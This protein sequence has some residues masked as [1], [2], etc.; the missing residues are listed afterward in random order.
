MISQSRGLPDVPAFRGRHKS[1][2][3]R[4]KV[5]LIGLVIFSASAVHAGGLSN[6][7]QGSSAAG[8][9]ASNCPYV[10]QTSR[11]PQLR[12]EVLKFVVSRC[13][14]AIVT[15]E[16]AGTYPQGIAI[17][18]DGK[19]VLVR[20]LTNDL[21]YG[22]AVLALPSRRIISTYASDGDVVRP[23]W[24][25]DGTKISFFLLNNGEKLRILNVWTYSTHKIVTVPNI[26]SY[27]ESQVTWSPD[28]RLIG[29]SDP[30]FGMIAVNIETFTKSLLTAAQ[31][32]SAFEWAPDSR[33]VLT[34]EPT[35]PARVVRINL[36]GAIVSSFNLR[37]GESGR[38]LAWTSD[39]AKVVL[40]TVVKDASSHKSRLSILDLNRRVETTLYENGRDI[41]D[42]QWPP[43][44]S[45]IVF[46]APNSWG[47]DLFYLKDGTQKPVQITDSPGWSDF[48]TN[49]PHADIVAYGH[50]SGNDSPELREKSLTTLNDDLLY[51]D[52][53]GILGGSQA[54]R[55]SIGSSSGDHLTGVLWK[56]HLAA[57][58]LVVELHNMTGAEAGSISSYDPEYRKKALMANSFGYAYLF[59]DCYSASLL[60]TDAGQRSHYGTRLSALV[61]SVQDALHIPTTRTALVAYSVGAAA[62]LS[63]I[64]EAPSRY[65]IV[66]LV[67]LGDQRASK[68]AGL[69]PYSNRIHV[70]VVEASLDYEGTVAGSTSTKK[71]LVGIGFHPE[72]VRTLIVNDVHLLMHPTSWI[73]IEAATFEA[74]GDS[75]E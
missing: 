1:P 25:P 31:P 74:L 9:I 61:D 66:T 43:N 17:S 4:S 11:M 60:D 67:G 44:N 19:H 6:L 24:S 12:Q 37:D 18:P 35:N 20:I 39:P 14:R 49:V 23:R 32:L 22:L 57:R 68:I 16:D 47:R 50:F 10:D 64:I 65:G 42:P 54:I 38:E 2:K 33:S 30:E 75:R 72:M 15:K 71:E 48:G 21:R 28:S 3:D 51:K 56:P 70:L 34:F 27:A 53:D 73:S 59:V 8:N 58:G 69:I 63:L 13:I 7:P 40:R 45:G 52:P 26:R 46:F 41:R 29:Y 55:V 5:F 36:L 62:A